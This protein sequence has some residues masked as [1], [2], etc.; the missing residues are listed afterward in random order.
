MRRSS[1][2]RTLSAQIARIIRWLFGVKK[3]GDRCMFSCDYVKQSETRETRTFI[4]WRCSHSI[5]VQKR[6]QI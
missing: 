4:C 1:E 5:T 2:V 6:V 3:R